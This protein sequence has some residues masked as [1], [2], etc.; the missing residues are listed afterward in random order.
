MSGQNCGN[1][2][3]ESVKR[4]VN[5]IDRRYAGKAKPGAEFEAETGIAADNLRKW[6]DGATAPGWRHAIRMILIF[7]PEFLH[8][9]L[10]NP[11]A[12]LDAAARAEMAAKLR[13]EIDERER[14]LADLSR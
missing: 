12:W 2:S 11:P 5:F 1:F 13:A 9:T 10:D 8:A 3:A 7:G 6:R 14:R 4:A